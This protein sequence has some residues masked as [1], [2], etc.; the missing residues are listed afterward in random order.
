MFKNIFKSIALF[1]L[2]VFN[3]TLFTW[4]A[5]NPNSTDKVSNLDKKDRN[6]IT[7]VQAKSEMV[8]ALPVIQNKL[9]NPIILKNSESPFQ[10]ES[11]GEN[12]SQQKIVLKFQS[13]AIKLETKEESRLENLLDNL[14]INESYTVHISSG[15]MPSNDETDSSKAAKLRA[16]TIA[17]V[18]YPHT[19]KI[20]M[21]YQPD[22]A[23]GTVVV[24]VLQAEI[25]K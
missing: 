15:P 12:G 5:N 18:I 2:L 11:H 16:Q 1:S 9:K 4:Y 3:A 7:D 20:T 14:N 17:R 6:I 24:D 23:I 19:Q 8:S 25:N 21:F 22:L 13:V 10:I